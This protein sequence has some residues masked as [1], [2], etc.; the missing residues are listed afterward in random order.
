PSL[1]ASARDMRRLLGELTWLQ[2][3]AVALASG[4]GEEI[5]FRGWPL[6]ETSLWLS[7][8][9]FGI[10]HFPPNRQW[11]YW[12]VF[13]GAMGFLLGWL[14]IWTGSIVFPILLHAGVNF[15]NL[16]LLLRPP[17]PR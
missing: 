2:A 10:V 14:Q 5:L 13:A 15:L 3:A 8:V 6:P 17:V 12:P 11:L 4:V 7:S 9:A 1:R 16:R